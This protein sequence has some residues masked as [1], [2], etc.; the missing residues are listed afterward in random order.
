[1]LESKEPLDETRLPELNQG[2]LNASKWE[3]VDGNAIY[4]PCI[5]GKCFPTDEQKLY[6]EILIEMLHEHINH[7]GKWRIVYRDP[8]KSNWDTI[9]KTFRAYMP[10]VIEMQFLDLGN[11]PQFVVSAE[12]RLDELLDWGFDNMVDLCEAA[13]TEHGALMK[14]IDIKESQKINAELPLL[15]P[16]NV[17]GSNLVH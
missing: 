1:M 3:W 13:F 14:V 6:G 16:Q 5:S 8:A 10:T 11:I 15:P 7:D 9:T 4:Y 12:R 17:V 2:E